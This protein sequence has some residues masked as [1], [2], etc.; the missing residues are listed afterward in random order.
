MVALALS[1]EQGNL[2][3]PIE[4]LEHF[5]DVEPAEQTLCVW[6]LNRLEGLYDAMLLEQSNSRQVLAKD[7]SE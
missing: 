3:N 7:L 5:G 4:S 6:L 1:L 2:G